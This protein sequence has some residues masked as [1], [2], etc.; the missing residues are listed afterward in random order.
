MFCRPPPQLTL[1]NT[2]V[3]VW[4]ASLDLPSSQIDEL[5]LTLS[6]DERVRAARYRFQ[7]DRRRFI[8]ARG[9]LRSLLGRYLELAPGR[10]ALHHQKNGKPTLANQLGG[11]QVQFNLSHAHERVV[12]AFAMERLVGIDIEYLP[13][14]IEYQPLAQRFFSAREVAM[15][16]SVPEPLRK[17]AFFNGWTRKEA[18]VK[19]TGEGLGRALDQFDVSLVPGEVACLLN[20]EACPE[21]ANRWAMSVLDVGPDYIGALVVQGGDW[22]LSC[23][24]CLG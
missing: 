15:F 2:D 10:L 6:D 1:T 9:T 23:W 8:A 12:Y 19:A 14:S 11:K 16:N 13:R 20:V 21:E 5:A 7:R 24:D 17:V 18:F 4:R 3:H 22:R